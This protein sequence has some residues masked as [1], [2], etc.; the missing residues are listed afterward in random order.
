[1]WP[2]IS[3]SCPVEDHKGALVRLPESVLGELAT[4]CG[5]GHDAK[6]EVRAAVRD[7]DV[8][9]VQRIEVR[10]LDRAE[11]VSRPCSMALGVDYDPV[12]E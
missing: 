1:M 6:G 8:R 11:L 4:K 5:L 2:T 12:H 7:T 10:L 9:G 3:P